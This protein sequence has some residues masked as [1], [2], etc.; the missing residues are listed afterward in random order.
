MES[1]K[2]NQLATNVAP[3]TTDLTLI[4][5][6]VTGELKKITWLQVASL[7]GSGA[8]LNFN[9]VTTNGNTTA[10]SIT[11]G[12]LTITG[13]DGVLKATAGVVGTYP[14]GG[15]NGVATLDSA[16][17]VPVSQL[18]SSI[19]EYKGTWNATTNVPALADGIGDNG[20]VYRV[21]VGGTINLGS[22][23]IT[24]SV[25]DYVIYNGTTWENLIQQILLQVYSEGLVLLL[26]KKEIILWT[27]LEMLL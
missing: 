12:G 21:S 6:P 8:S 19:M 13:A 9:D 17:K 10:N 26:L 16:G 5:D 2:I 3:V 14:Y 1:K 15:A 22:G 27:F 20:D 18:P 24:F 23:S 11:I 7:I 25:G 4:G